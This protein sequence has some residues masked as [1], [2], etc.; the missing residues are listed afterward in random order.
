MMN[1]LPPP[2]WMFLFLAIAGVASY[3]LPAFVSLQVLALGALLIV[4]AVAMAVSAVIRFR[5]AGTEIDPMSEANKA[6]IVQGPYRLTRNPMYLSLVLL[7]LGIAFAVGRWPMFIVP[8]LVFLVASR[9]HIPFEEDK[10]RRQFGA[11][12]DAYTAK[13]RRWI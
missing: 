11:A 7:S 13:V 4:V 2:I 5:T 9:N 6:L 12:Y 1:K 10:M 8:A 3:V